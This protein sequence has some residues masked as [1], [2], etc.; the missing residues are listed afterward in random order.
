MA[1]VVIPTYNRAARIERTLVSALNQEYE[2]VE[3]IV[4]D[5][6]ST[7][8]TEAVVRNI[9]A[10]NTS[11]AG[12]RL[13]YIRQQNSGACVARNRGM[14]HARGHYL[15]FLDSDDL[16]KPG[17]IR[18]Q[19]AAIERDDSECAICD[20][21]VVDESGSL[22]AIR[23]NNLHP[24]EFVRSY[25]STSVSTVLMRRDTVP[26]GLQWNPR[27]Y[28]AQDVDFIFK[29][30]STVRLWSY[31]DYPF[32]Q[33]VHHQDDRVSDSYR[34]G[35]QYREMRRSYAS[36]LQSNSAFITG[37][38]DELRRAYFGALRRRHARDVGATVVPRPIRTII[39]K[40]LGRQAVRRGIN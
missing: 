36:F 26:P 37:D 19:V 7:D 30:L 3:I 31:V 17:L 35:M 34:L 22:I 27:L 12:K 10:D 39:K 4:V 25:T 6:G 15:M 16:I 2:N 28:R 29:Y 5:D 40:F 38:A 11:T 23:Q 18:A 32:F 33:Y 13:R 8:D 24:H 20:F 21:E 14:M 9:A 1:S